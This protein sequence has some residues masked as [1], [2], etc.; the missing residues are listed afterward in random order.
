MG[1][2]MC[3]HMGVDLGLMDA[4]EPLGTCYV[5]ERRGFRALC[6]ERQLAESVPIQGEAP[7]MTLSRGGCRTQKTLSSRTPAPTAPGVVAPRLSECCI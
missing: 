3:L 7:G 1:K 4:L 2:G 5:L 6:S